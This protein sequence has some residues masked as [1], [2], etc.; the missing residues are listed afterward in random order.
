M[1]R[2][3]VQLTP[4]IDEAIKTHGRAFYSLT[5]MTG[6]FNEKW[7]LG[8]WRK[9]LADGV[10][11]LWVM[12][13]DNKITG[14]MGGIL[15][16]CI[17]SGVIIATESFW[18]VDPNHRKGMGGIRLYQEFRKWARQVGVARIQLA[19]VSGSMEGELDRFYVEQGFKKLET[20]YVMEL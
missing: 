15:H 20:L 16:P 2:R 9:I 3:I 19:H 8:I 7:F 12:E 13:N 18:Y 6:E 17:F 1:T 5:G 4:E 11:A 14:I 10:G